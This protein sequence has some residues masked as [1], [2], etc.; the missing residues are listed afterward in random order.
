M[1]DVKIK[2]TSQTLELLDEAF[3]RIKELENTL[4][5]LQMFLNGAGILPSVHYFDGDESEDDPAD[6]PE[7]LWKVENDRLYISNKV[8]DPKG[9][10]VYDHVWVFRNEKNKIE[11]NIINPGELIPPLSSLYTRFDDNWWRYEGGFLHCLELMNLGLPYE[12]E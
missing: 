7:P 9:S 2:F 6:K 11:A 5:E 10:L 4:T 12:V 8:I 1:G 3:K